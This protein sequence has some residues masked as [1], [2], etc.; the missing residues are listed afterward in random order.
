VALIVLEFADAILLIALVFYASICN[1]QLGS[2]MF[3][4]ASVVLSAE[5]ALMVAPL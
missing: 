1:V 5:P 2:N 3:Q 4:L